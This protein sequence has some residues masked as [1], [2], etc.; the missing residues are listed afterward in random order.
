MTMTEEVIFMGDLNID[1]F[2]TQSRYT[3]MLNNLLDS[4]GLSQI[5]T[6]STRITLTTQTLIDLICISNSEA[7]ISSGV[8]S[9]NA[10]SDHGLVYCTLSTNNK[11][12]PVVHRYRDYH[13]LDINY[14]TSEL[15]SIPWRVLYDLEDVDE[16]IEFFNCAILA[17]QNRHAPIITRSFSTSY[18]P[19][20]TDNLKFFISLQNKAL[21]KFKKIRCATDFEYYKQLKNYI[22]SAIRQ[23]KKAFMEK[24]IRRDKNSAWKNLRNLNLG[25]QKAN[26]SIP[27][28]LSNVA[29]INEYYIKTVPRND[30]DFSQLMEEYEAKAASLKRSFN[31]EETDEI[32]VLK[33][34]ASIKS[35]SIGFDGIEIKFLKLCCPFLLPY[36]THIINYCIR[37][38]VYPANW[39]IAKIIP[40]PKNK[41]PQTLKDLRPISILS[42]PSKILEKILNEQLRS[43]LLSHAILPDEQAGFRAG[44]SCCTALLNVTDNILK[45]TDR[46]EI[47]ILVLLDY[48]KAFDTINHSV[49]ISV[50]HSIGLSNHASALITNFLVNRKQRVVLNDNVS[51]ALDVVAGVPQGSILGPLLYILYTSQFPKAVK[52]SKLQLYADDTQILYSCRPDKLDEGCSKICTDLQIL[53]DLSQRH[54]L[55]LNP[56]KSNYIVFGPKKIRNALA[57]NLNVQIDG[58]SINRQT[59]VKNLGVILDEDLRFKNHVTNTIRKAFSNLK[60]I[61]GYK[62]LLNRNTKILLT[63]ALVLSHFNFCDV[64]Y[65]A[66]IDYHD[67][68]RIQK[69]QNACLRLIHGIRRGKSTSHKLVQ[70]NWLN[71]KDRRVLHSVCLYQKVVTTKVPLNLYDKITFRHYVHNVNIRSKS[72]ITPPAHHTALFERSFSY[73]IAKTY[74]AVPQSLKP[75]SLKAFAEQYAVLLKSRY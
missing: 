8:T 15:K 47:T 57:N 27:V 39:K 59:E 55:R 35:N 23:E 12:T 1:L 3:T 40:I 49:L 17:L 33:H 14:L 53:S 60:S 52:H 74:N 32:T 7:V 48:S 4:V 58:V 25:K 50:L 46:G 73:N 18:K 51:E 19:W 11:S 6:E 22:T 5:I 36:L 28:S 67:T 70:T 13:N 10:I 61:Y 24:Q 9:V 2:N 75:K 65:N 20:M 66:C 21:A 44:H 45:A 34:L 41:D 37:N 62:D 63:D 56:E 71:M 16:K 72:Y 43:Y 69:V 30:D 29:D 54:S 64:L 31:F 38:S 26:I 68:K 42:A